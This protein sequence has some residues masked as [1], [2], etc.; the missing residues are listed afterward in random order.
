MKFPDFSV[1]F[2]LSRLYLLPPL[3]ITSLEYDSIFALKKIKDGFYYQSMERYSEKRSTENRSTEKT[4]TIGNTSTEITS[5]RKQR[6]LG[7]KVHLE[8]VRKQGHKSRNIHVGP[9]H[10]NIRPDEQSFWRVEQPPITSRRPQDTVSLA[11][12]RG[13]AGRHCWG[14]SKTPS[15]CCGHAV[16]E[17]DEESCYSDTGATVATVHWIC[18]WRSWR[19]GL[20]GRNW[21]QHPSVTL[22]T[23]DVNMTLQIRR[24]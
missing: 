14:V 6:P 1:R 12:A 18:R 10:P 7:N 21:P 13:V 9:Q 5:T 16:A 19:K 22:L 4:S 17:E 2:L 3:R 24:E 23:T 8:R 20:Y 15:S 11:V